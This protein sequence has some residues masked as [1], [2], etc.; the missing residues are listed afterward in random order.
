VE[1]FS[2]DTQSEVKKILFG[3]KIVGV[4]IRIEQII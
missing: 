4:W 1:K 3:E 2:Y